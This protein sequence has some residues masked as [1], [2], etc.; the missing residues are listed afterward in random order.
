[1]NYVDV[2]ATIENEVF[3]T[4]NLKEMDQELNYVKHEVKSLTI[5]LADQKLITGKEKR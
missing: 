5:H 4:E 1:M 2:K 3:H